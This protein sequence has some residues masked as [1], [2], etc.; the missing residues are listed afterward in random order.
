MHAK[1]GFS[2][3]E[4]LVVIGVVVIVVGLT[5]PALRTVRDNAKRLSHAEIIRSDAMLIGIYAA[6]HKDVYPRES[7]N[8]VACVMNWGS[9]LVRANTV[10]SITDL[11][12][13]AI[14][15]AEMISYGMSMAM[16][17]DPEL[18]E[19]GRTVAEK[20]RKSRDILVDRVRVPSL[21]GLLWRFLITN[22]TPRGT[23]GVAVR[24]CC[25]P[26]MRDIGEVAMADGSV[27]LGVWTDF[28]PAAFDVQDGIGIP[29][30]STWFGV[31]GW[32]SPRIKESR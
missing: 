21:K 8:P 9:V 4:L 27:R 12:P 1:R 18:M 30:Q 22:D 15:S 29:V 10:S 31:N 3:L 2:L 17:Y 26:Q 5:L 20:G 32:D 19:P 11:D 13:T 6:D 7:E 23:T 16:V 28:L 25:D 24:W 14:R